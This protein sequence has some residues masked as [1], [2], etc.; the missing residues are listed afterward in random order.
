MH[1]LSMS[2]AAPPPLSHQ[3]AGLMQPPTFDTLSRNSKV[4]TACSASTHCLLDLPLSFTLAPCFCKHSEVWNTCYTHICPCPDCDNLCVYFC[5]FA[6]YTFSMRL[7]GSTV[8]IRTMQSVF[9]V[10][11]NSF[12]RVHLLLLWHVVVVGSM[13]NGVPVGARIPQ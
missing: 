4:L 9:W 11:T 5:N 1:V 6:L 7:I 3:M 12:S 2:G 10:M 13:S 8:S